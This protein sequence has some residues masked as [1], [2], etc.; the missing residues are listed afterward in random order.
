VIAGAFSVVKDIQFPF[1]NSYKV[2]ELLKNIPA[3]ERIVTDIGCVNNVSAFTGK[4]L[5]CIGPDREVSFVQWNDEFK[6]VT[7]NPYANSLSKLFQKQG[8][9]KVYLI[10]IYTPQTINR[11]DSL[12]EKTFQVLLIDKREGAIEKWSNLYLYQIS[13]Q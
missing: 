11:F 4:A 9:K 2:D 5:Y 12:L 7:P 6:L 10:S 13:T 1:S 8:L 3:N